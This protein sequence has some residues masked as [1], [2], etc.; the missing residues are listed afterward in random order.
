MWC[1]VKG[2][3]LVSAGVQTW[4][5][6]V[7]FTVGGLR[8]ETYAWR[9]K[10]IKQVALFSVFLPFL[11]IRNNFGLL[12][13]CTEGQNSRERK[14]LYKN[15]RGMTCSKGPKVGVELRLPKPRTIATIHYMERT[16]QPLSYNE[17][18][19]ISVCLKLQTIIWLICHEC[20]LSHELKV[21][22]IVKKRNIW[23]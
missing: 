14:K 18:I 12:Y 17:I 9:Y 10:G 4:G 8:S 19:F 20:V 2:H 21:Y 22:N 7:N 6:I 5:E 16:S 1:K 3:A 13:H 15:V 11:I 23:M